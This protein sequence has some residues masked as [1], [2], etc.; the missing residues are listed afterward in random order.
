VDEDCAV[1]NELLCRRCS[2]SRLHFQE[3]GTPCLVVCMKG[4]KIP[5]A[6]V[7]AAVQSAVDFAK[8]YLG[9]A[10]SRVDSWSLH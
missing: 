1:L 2:G 7:N 10:K 6:L 9:P 8:L 3:A 5:S 4:K